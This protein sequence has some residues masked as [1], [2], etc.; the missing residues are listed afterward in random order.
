MDRYT[1][2]YIIVA[3]IIWFIAFKYTF[4]YCQRDFI[5]LN[6][7]DRFPPYVES[8]LSAV[9]AV[10]IASSLAIFWLPF[11]IVGC[12]VVMIALGGY[13]VGLIAN[14]ILEC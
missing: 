7:K 5:N 12:A 3:V 14:T 9:A 2:I 1:T 11:M 6:E 10:C 13:V 8:S 4:C